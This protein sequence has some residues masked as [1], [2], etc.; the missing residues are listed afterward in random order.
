MYHRMLH[1]EVK[2]KPMS[3]YTIVNVIDKEPMRG[4]HTH[5][6]AYTL[7]ITR[8]QDLTGLILSLIHI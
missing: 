7:G 8:S 4:L 1:E 5:A 2:P 6:L 3:P